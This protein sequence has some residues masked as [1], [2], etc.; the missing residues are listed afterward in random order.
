MSS[1]GSEGNSTTFF[2][3]HRSGVHREIHNV[4]REQQE[5]VQCAVYRVVPEDERRDI[6]EMLFAPLGPTAG[7][8]A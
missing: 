1:W 7:K 5:A 2:K 3:T 6:M 8:Y 4:E